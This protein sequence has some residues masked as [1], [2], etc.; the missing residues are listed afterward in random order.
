MDL[1]Y[2]D[3]SDIHFNFKAGISGYSKFEYSDM[4]GNQLIRASENTIGASEG[5]HL[6]TTFTAGARPN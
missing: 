1:N 5:K 2:P 6:T 3:P 4:L